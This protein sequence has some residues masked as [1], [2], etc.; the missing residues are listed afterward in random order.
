MCVYCWLLLLHFTL[1]LFSCRSNAAP[2]CLMPPC[3]SVR[4]Y[5]LFSYYYILSVQTRRTLFLL[6]LHIA[7][8]RCGGLYSNPHGTIF[9]KERDDMLKALI[10]QPA[11]ILLVY[12]YTWIGSCIHLLQY[13]TGASRRSEGWRPKSKAPLFTHKRLVHIVV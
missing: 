2:N 7:A 9:R 4:A 8:M 12:I 10:H 5:F 3:V 1:F 13:K 11:P 6:F